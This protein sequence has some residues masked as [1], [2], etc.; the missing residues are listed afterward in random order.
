MHLQAGKNCLKRPN[1]LGICDH[2]HV[3]VYVCVFAQ[4][5]K[6]SVGLSACLH[7]RPVSN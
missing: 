7:R 1:Y 3:C 2:V 4:H 6:T 5:K